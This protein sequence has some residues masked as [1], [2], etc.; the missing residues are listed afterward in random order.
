MHGTYDFREITARRIAESIPRFP[1]PACDIATG[2]ENRAEARIAIDG[3]EVSFGVV[4]VLV[5]IEGRPDDWSLISIEIPAN[6]TVMS[7]WQARRAPRWM[8]EDWEDVVIGGLHQS[9]A[10]RRITAAVRNWLATDGR[11]VDA[12]CRAI[13]E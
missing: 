9:A 5:T 13:G 6:D 8:R 3:L 2:A 4:D 12:L 10:D 1:Y 7:H 11:A